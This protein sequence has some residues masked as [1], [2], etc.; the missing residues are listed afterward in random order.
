MAPKTLLV[1]LGAANLASAHFG[2]TYP[3]WRADTLKPTNVT[4]FSQWTYPC[5]GVPYG[6]GNVTDWPLD[7]GAVELDLHHDW[8]Y[9]FINLGLEANGNVSTHN[10]TLTPQFWNATGSGTLCVEKLALPTPAQDGQ[11]ASL[12]VITVGDSGAGLYNCADIR[13]TSNA[14]NPSSEQ[15]KTEGVSVYTVKEQSANGTIEGGAGNSTGNSTGGN[16]GSSDA[17]GSG[18]H[19]LALTTFV[20][21]SFVFAFGMS[22]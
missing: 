12:Q 17:A 3:E 8:T 11:R 5:A 21:L 7:G 6:A 18:V 14:T 9:V 1:A 20:G 15:C 22:L 16:G 4:G 19:M 13:F 10:I 2:L